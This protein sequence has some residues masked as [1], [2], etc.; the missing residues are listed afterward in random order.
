MERQW[1]NVDSSHGHFFSI[2]YD[3]REYEQQDLQP[4]ENQNITFLTLKE[5]KWCWIIK[6]NFKL[7]EIETNSIIKFLLT[8][9]YEAVSLD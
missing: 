7:Q 5:S 3:D 4:S 1:G 6:C 2:S 9:V 8:G